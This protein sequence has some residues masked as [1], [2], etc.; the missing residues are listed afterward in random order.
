[1]CQEKG[2][3][4]KHGRINQHSIS[5]NYEKKRRTLDLKDRLGLCL[6]AGK[7]IQR[8]SKTLFILKNWGRFHAPLPIQE[9]LLW[10]FGYPNCIL[11]T[12]RQSARI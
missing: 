8:S 12:Y 4:A 2:S 9:R 6:W 7:T 10:A 1:M 5:R 11:R 3:N